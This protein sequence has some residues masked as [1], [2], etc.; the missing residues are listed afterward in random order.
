MNLCPI[1]KSMHDNSHY[2]INYDNK[3]YICNKHNETFVKYC[4]DCK[5][6]FAYHV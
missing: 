1:C 4:E 5:I 3:N 6:D 2:I